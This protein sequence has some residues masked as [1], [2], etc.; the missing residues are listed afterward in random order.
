L[1]AYKFFSGFHGVNGR[2]WL[3]SIVRNASYSWLQKNRR[4][5]LLTPAETDQF[6]SENPAND[7]GEIAAVNMN[8]ELLR[9][10]LERLPAEFREIIVLRELEGLSYKEIAGVASVPIGTVMSRLARAREHLR[11]ELAKGFVDC[12]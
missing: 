2:A 11:K 6:E 5:E 7:P 1:R 10:A 4:H 9:L 8:K 12:V 3:L